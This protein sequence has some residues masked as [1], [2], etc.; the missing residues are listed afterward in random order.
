M[1]ETIPPAR[2][3]RG[4]TAFAAAAVALLLAAAYGWGLVRFAPIW[5]EP[6]RCLVALEMT[7][8]G[9][10]VV[11]R[12]LGEPYLNKPP[13]QNWLIAA[14]AGFR[15]RRV[16]PA[17]ARLVSLAAVAA[18]AALAAAWPVARGTPFDRRLAALAFLTQGIVVQYGRTGETDALFSL[19]TTL[20]LWLHARGARDGRPALAWF[21]PQAAV[22]LG[23][24]TKGLAP[25]FFYPAAGLAA[26]WR[27]R[28]AAARGGEAGVRPAAR[29]GP[30]LA[31]AAAGLAAALLVVAAW[32]APYAARSDAAALA[33]RAAAE[34]LRSG[35]AGRPASEFFRHLAS[36]PLDV[37]AGLLPWSL[38]LAAAARPDARRRWRAALRADPALAVAAIAWAAAFA[39]L[40]LAPGAKGRYLLPVAPAAAVALSSLVACRRDA[41][42]C[43]R[44]ARR[45]RV[46]TAALA[47]AG[48][49]YAA[50]HAFGQA[51]RRAARADAARAAAREIASRAADGRPVVGAR[52][53]PFAV[54]FEL[55]RQLGRP[56]AR[57][58][59]GA[60]A[61]W[62]VSTDGDRSSGARAGAV[63][64]GGGIVLTS[65]A[66]G[67][68]PPER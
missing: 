26:A 50:V 12:L 20:A 40:W 39:V 14:A 48:L 52:D 65:R 23:V 17:A 29:P 30:A 35:P 53:L 37:A 43:G 68:D 66:A 41:V 49:A 61:Y 58:P 63:W 2:S 42:R 9:D 45:I 25:L 11:P 15:P 19:W 38:A 27:R 28:A 21:W 5:E 57:Q 10:Y 31:A 6:R 13:L 51:P 16:T 54:A 62:I 60:G 8:T 22:G 64:T 67:G 32:A 3:P 56:L 4:A 1:R 47:A 44:E 7:L 55:T 46:A 36:F 34:T 33:S 18:M 24:L 59:P